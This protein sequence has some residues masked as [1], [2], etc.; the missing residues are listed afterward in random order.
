M[1]CSAA[2]GALTITQLT[3]TEAT[4]LLPDLST[5]LIDVVEGGASVGFLAPLPRE[6]ALAFWK[7][8]VQGVALGERL[9]LG[10]WLRGR[11]IGSVQVILAL[12]ENQPH[13][14][15]I[16]KLQVLREAQRQG[17]GSALMR[18][19]EERAA[20][21]GKTLLSLDTTTGEAAERLYLQLGWERFGVMPGHALFPDGRLSDTSF[22]YKRIG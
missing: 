7:P 16:A 18:A 22:F 5:I 10:A 2:G 1:N 21:A 4:K 6:K 19:A 20:A 15:E 3:E 8:I 13:R 17:A 9:L 11:L 12:P 14:G